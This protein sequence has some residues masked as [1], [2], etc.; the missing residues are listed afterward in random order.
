MF[1]IFR[2]FLLTN[3]ILFS[4]RESSD[5]SSQHTF[6]FFFFG[7]HLFFFFFF[8][9]GHGHG[10]QKT[11]GFAPQSSLGS[12]SPSPHGVSAERHR[13]LRDRAV[14][15]DRQTSMSDPLP[16]SPDYTHSHKHHNDHSISILVS[17]KPI[18]S[19]IRS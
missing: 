17:I 14:L 6:F 2:L 16:T 18:T 12:S 13:G 11:S 19:C 7:L 1:V 10:G 5:Q 15:C 4:A 8:F 3:F 9:F